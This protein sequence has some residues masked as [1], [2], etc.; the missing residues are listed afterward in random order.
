MSI[1]LG[2][3]KLAGDIIKYSHNIGDIFYTSRT[4][5]ILVGAV[6]CNGATYQTTDYTGSGSIGELLRAGKLPYISLS[7]YTS[8]L[9]AH[10]SVRAFGW[11][12]GSS[13]AFRVPTLQNV[14][15]EAGQ[16]ASAGEYISAGL[17]NI[18]GDVG[19]NAGIGYVANMSYGVSVKESE[20]S[21][22]FFPNLGCN[23][24]ATKQ[25]QQ[26][27]DGKSLGFD[28]SRSS[29]IYGNS[30][31]VQPNS[32]KYRAMVQL[33][34]AVTDE[35]LITCEN[36]ENDVESLKTSLNNK[37]TNCITEIP[38][39]IK[40]E[41]NNGTLTLKA[42]SKVYKPNGPGTFSEFII[43]ADKSYSGT[44]SST[45]QA[46]VF[47]DGGT[48]IDIYPLNN[49]F[50]GTSLPSSFTGVFYNT[51]T[52][53]I[54]LYAAGIKLGNDHYLPVA[55]VTMSGS[56]GITSI[57][58]VFNGFGYIGSTV[59]ALPGV[60]GLI[61]NGRNADGSLK[62]QEAIITAV[63]TFTASGYGYG[64]T[65][66]I[67]ND[68]A[69]AVRNTMSY[70][71]G[72][73]PTWFDNGLYATWFDTESNKLFYTSDGGA[74]WTQTYMFMFGSMYMVN[75]GHLDWP[76]TKQVFESLDYNDSE[77]IAHQ[78]MPSDKSIE[79]T[80]GA[81]G[82]SYLMPADG[83]LFAVCGG[84][85]RIQSN[86]GMAITTSGTTLS[87]GC[88]LVPV[89]KGDTVIVQYTT[90]QYLGIRF[91]YANGAQ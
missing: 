25:T 47:Y 63:R 90:T 56:S 28:A 54:N 20:T 88:A 62:N 85:V 36:V 70:S 86:L 9:A 27:S 35:A 69:I 4:D 26:G 7:Q 59:F 57:D 72:S 12:G 33:Y 3:K 64:L 40:L 81:S 18:T 41:L 11:D 68:G 50:S 71:V 39:D 22:A 45:Y 43:N 75:A 84:S 5:T 49:S 48:T 83:Y 2:S 31:T 16:A 53:K 80:A 82:A 61:P 44:D 52:N 30:N 78:G 76:K 42:G 17:P 15:L 1:W 6:E 58:Q 38:Q 34:N 24:T 13:T 91:Y 21:G 89:K 79:I 10:G 37:I 77:Y 67:Q 32:V 19:K 66:S 60:K 73:K 55:L 8:D 14:F 51:S 46:L 29:S 65:Y 74:T 87:G 23:Y